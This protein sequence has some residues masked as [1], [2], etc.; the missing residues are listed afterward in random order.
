MVDG[1][2]VAEMEGSLVAVG[3][4]SVGAHGWQLVCGAGCC[5]PGACCLVIGAGRCG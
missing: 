1:N 3:L 4:W 2:L 5:R